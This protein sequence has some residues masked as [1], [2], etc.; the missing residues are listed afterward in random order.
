MPLEED[1]R[2]YKEEVSLR[3]LNTERTLTQQACH[4]GV[5]EFAVMR[6]A[7]QNRG[8]IG[9][10]TR[11]VVVADAPDREFSGRARKNAEPQT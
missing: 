11:N 4:G 6:W 1:A 8:Y 2:G 9:P 5:G 10:G 3:G 7:L